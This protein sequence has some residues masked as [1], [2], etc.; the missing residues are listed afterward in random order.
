M[1]FLSALGFF[2]TVWVGG[3]IGFSR[4]AKNCALICMSFSDLDQWDQEA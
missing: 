4:K 2:L 1:L 3:P